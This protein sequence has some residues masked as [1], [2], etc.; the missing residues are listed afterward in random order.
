MPAVSVL[1]N[2]RKYGI[3]GTAQWMA[4][5]ALYRAWLY[6]TP[7]G[8]REL[9][10]DEL[11]GVDTDGYISE[12]DL[13]LPAG[14]IH[15]APTRP[16]RLIQAV[17]SIHI[18][19]SQF[20]FIDIGCGK[21]RALL[22]AKKIGFRRTVGVELSSELAQI[23]ERNAPSADIHNANATE[24][25]FPPEDSVVYLYNPFWGEAMHTLAKRLAESVKQTPR[26]AYVIYLNPFCAEAFDNQNYA[27]LVFKR[28][29]LAIYQCSPMLQ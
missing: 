18:E 7:A 28:N 22:V 14:S 1:W 25:P 3:I 12:E 9:R 4:R 11:H 16:A 29:Y 27:P 5:A 13:L 10:F 2:I 17:K 24:F 21:G 19:P 23:A 26:T 15:Y 8:R 20:T 6:S